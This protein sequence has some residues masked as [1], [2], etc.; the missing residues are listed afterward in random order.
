MS[1]YLTFSRDHSRFQM[2][3]HMNLNIAAFLFPVHRNDH[4]YLSEWFPLRFGVF[5]SYLNLDIS[6]K[7]SFPM[8]WFKRCLWY[9]FPSVIAILYQCISWLPKILNLMGICSFFSLF[10]F[11][12][13]LYLL[14]HGLLLRITLNSQ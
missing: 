7:L 12:L 5:N 11:C 8:V 10:F 6:K 14:A 2:Y 4:K 1:Y 13:N 3:V 9:W